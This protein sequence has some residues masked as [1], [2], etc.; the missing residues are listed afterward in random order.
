[1]ACLI[2]YSYSLYQKG[3][4]SVW[5]IRAE[6]GRGDSPKYIGV[7]GS[8]MS[9]PPDYD[10]KLTDDLHSELASLKEVSVEETSEMG[11]LVER[12]DGEFRKLFED[13]P[14]RDRV[15]AFLKGI[16]QAP[17][18]ASAP[19]KGPVRDTLIEMASMSSRLDQTEEPSEGLATAESVGRRSHELVH[20]IESF[21][22]ALRPTEIITGLFHRVSAY[23]SRLIK[24][25][26]AKIREFAKRIDATSFSIGF[27]IPPPS[28]TVTINFGGS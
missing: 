1:M 14:H 7:D 2:W 13:P 23:L 10:D 8:L 25:V 21:L 12:L 26:V 17:A 11:R 9:Y 24:N 19:S 3:R 6:F 18:L 4:A 5:R 22:P 27:T 16:T 15:M 28:F 20:T